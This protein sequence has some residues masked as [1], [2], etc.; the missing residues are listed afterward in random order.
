[1]NAVQRDKCYVRRLGRKPSGRQFTFALLSSIQRAT[2]GG[3]TREQ[4]LRDRH[5]MRTAI[6]AL[7]YLCLVIGLVAL[8][9]WRAR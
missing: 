4:I 2:P 5:P 7:P 6:A 3:V 1:M 8:Y 9:A